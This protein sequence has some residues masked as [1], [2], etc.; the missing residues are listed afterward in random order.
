MIAGER[1]ERVRITRRKRQGRFVMDARALRC[2]DERR[3]Q[4]AA[5]L[6]VLSEPGDDTARRGLRRVPRRLGG[7][8]R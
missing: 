3:A 8:G 2:L 4:L 6:T 7:C 1:E 5:L